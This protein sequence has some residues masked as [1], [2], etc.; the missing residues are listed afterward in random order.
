MFC[1]SGGAATLITSMLPKISKQTAELFQSIFGDPKQFAFGVVW[2]MIPVVSICILVLGYVARQDKSKCGTLKH[3]LQQFERSKKISM[4]LAVALFAFAAA[5]LAYEWY[6]LMQMYSSCSR[7]AHCAAIRKA[8][9]EILMFFAG[10]LFSIGCCVALLCFNF[11][12]GH[13]RAASTQ[14]PGT[15]MRTLGGRKVEAPEDLTTKKTR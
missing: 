13:K 2:V 10:F 4:T 11:D 9:A 6:L 5:G 8:A 1:D 3:Y 12:I 15:V 14:R 7:T